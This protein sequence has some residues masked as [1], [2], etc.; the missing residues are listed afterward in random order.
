MRDAWLAL[1]RHFANVGLDAFVIMPNHLHAVVLIHSADPSPQ[2]SPTS[3]PSPRKGTRT[4]SLAAIVQ[5][6]KSVSAWA[7]KAR[8]L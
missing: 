1:P 5:T 7:K 4:G 3:T 6:F 2:A 8:A